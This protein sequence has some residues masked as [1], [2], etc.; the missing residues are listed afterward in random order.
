MFG[1]VKESIPSGQEQ[2]YLGGAKVARLQ[3]LLSQRILDQL[4]LY[5]TYTSRAPL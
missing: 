4:L 5:A 1:K 2:Q 3:L